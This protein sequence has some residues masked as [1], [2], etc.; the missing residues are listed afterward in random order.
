MAAQDKPTDAHVENTSRSDLDDIQ[1][2]KNVDGDVAL[3]MFDDYSAL[4]SHIDP[5]A[6]RRLVR[7][8]DMYIIPFIC[9][10]YLITYIDKATLGYAAIFGMTKDAH[11]VGTQYSWLGSI[12]Y[13][14][15]LFFEYPTSFAMQKVSVAKWLGVNIF[16]WG[17]ICMALAYLLI[18]A[19]WYTVE[20]QPIRVGYWSTFLG[21]ANSFGGLLAYGIGNIKGG[22]LDSWR[23]Q[24]IVIGS[25]SAAWGI[26]VFLFLAENPASAR[27]LSDDEKK[28]AVERV[29]E[30][31]TGIKN[32][33]FKK[34]Q[35]IEALLD[36]KTWF[37]FF[38]GL[39]TQ[40]VNGSVSN[41]GT[42]TI[43]GFGYS[44]LVTTLLQ[45]PY[46]AIIIFAVLSAMYLQRWLPGQK[47]C[48]V[49][50]L[51]VL[52]A[53]AGVA[54]IT[55]LPA[56]SKHARLACY[57]LTA[58]YTA[59]FAICMS[60]ITANTCGSTKRTTVNAIFFISY[61]AGNII[62][63]FA[64]KPAEAPVYR[65]GIIAILVAYCVEIVVLVGFAGYLRMLNG[66]KERDET[67]SHYL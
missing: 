64:F 9:I 36:P 27:F 40:V 49:A 5:K 63:P 52:P 23:Y 53:L 35:L 59:S 17:G 12:F 18:T 41:F 60:L 34:Y 16:L 44:S 57:Y 42:L 24:F 21:L 67:K 8:L 47:R 28:M 45:I 46:G 13:F 43:K 14:R 22:A 7:K 11:L 38:F 37:L 29:R 39:S 33:T 66:R 25:F 15:Y 3:K 20:E 50:G 51:Y 4:N 65:S 54:G 31:Q 56:S 2:L 55:A 48:I 61:C 6:E 62:G 10:T 30:N 26:I 58:F 32:T 19:M 1:N